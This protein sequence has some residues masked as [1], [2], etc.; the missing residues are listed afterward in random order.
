MENACAFET[1]LTKMLCAELHFLVT[2]P[3][4]F[5]YLSAVLCTTTNC[6]DHICAT[7]AEV[8]IFGCLEVGSRFHRRT[9]FA[10]RLNLSFVLQR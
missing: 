8:C 3:L 1:T 6:Q 4:G 2:L 7:A 10:R 9:Q 5:L